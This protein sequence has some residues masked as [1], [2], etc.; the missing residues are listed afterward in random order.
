MKRQ[1]NTDCEG[2]VSKNDNA[3]ELA[4]EFI[5]EGGK[6][7]AKLSKYDDFLADIAEKPGYKAGDTLRLILPFF[8]AYGVTDTSIREFSERNILLVPG[9]DIMLEYVQSI[10]P[11]FIIS[12]SYRP[13]I[14]ALCDT[15][16]F[17]VENTYCTELAIDD[18]HIPEAEISYLKGLHDEILALPGIEIPASASALE[19]LDDGSIRCIERLDRI[20]WEEF[21]GTASGK[22]LE[23]INPMGGYEKAEA[24]KKSC[25][26]TGVELRDVMYAGDSITDMDA[27]KLVRGAGGITVSFN[28]NRYAI[29]AADIACLS[30]NALILAALAF[31]FRED[32]PESILN[33]ASGWES[34]K[35][36]LEDMMKQSLPPF[37]AEGTS[38]YL[39]SDSDRDELVSR[40]ESFRKTVR[41]ERIGRLG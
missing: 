20:F 30:S 33:L 1:F 19:D 7:F 37:T 27:M 26:R 34:E 16:G 40:S 25:E 35:A 32:G 23:E 14:N 11:A 12:T 8:K 17:P 15:I 24:I 9:A 39:I 3:F 2:P 31:K 4:Q 18:Y 5:P 10:M 29:E 36:A 41:G 21:P 6:L 13:Y 38:L 22:M 28:G